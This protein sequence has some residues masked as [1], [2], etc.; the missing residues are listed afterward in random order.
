MKTQN[1]IYLGTVCLERTRWGKRE[2]SF[3]VSAW[4]PRFASDGFDGIELWS[5]HYT[6]ASAGEQQLLEAAAPIAIYNSYAKFTDEDAQV[7]AE[8]AASIRKLAAGAVKYN[9]G[10]DSALLPVYKH[11]LLQWAE[12]LP[13][14]CQLLCECHPGTQLETPAAAEAFHRDLDP[15]RFG[16]IVHL[17]NTS[18][19]GLTNWLATFGPRIRH[20]HI[21]FRDPET[22]PRNPA[23]QPA[24]A[25]AFQVLRNNAFA[26]SITME[27]TRGIGRDENI[28]ELYRNVCA[29]QAFVR[30]QLS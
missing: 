23:N 13:A 7:R 25:A 2:A 3:P 9:V 11:N 29:D 10:N 6:R 24:L 20:V 26:G 5:F 8:D 21:Q 14:N 30:S 28:E 15:E 19:E 27:F 18:T 17:G 12:A 16:I 22:D 4:L 1:S